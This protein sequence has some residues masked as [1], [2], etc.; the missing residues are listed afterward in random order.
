MMAGGDL[1]IWLVVHLQSLWWSKQ[2]STRGCHPY[3]P[4]DL[5]AA[6]LF[7]MLRWARKSLLIFCKNSLFF[8]L[9][10]F[11]LFFFKWQAHSF[12]IWQN[13]K[14]VRAMWKQSRSKSW[15]S[16]IITL[17][18]GREGSLCAKFSFWTEYTDVFHMFNIMCIQP[19]VHC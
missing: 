13:L 10:L 4:R 1:S 16:M 15:F 5:V 6:K 3:D 19:H 7:V 2:G 8:F 11:F 14:V 17:L 12:G 9:F 18:I